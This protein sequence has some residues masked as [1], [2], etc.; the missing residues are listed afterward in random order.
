MTRTAGSAFP[1]DVAE[2]HQ[3]VTDSKISGSS[4]LRVGGGSEEIGS[5][6]VLQ[7]V[8]MPRVDDPLEV[9]P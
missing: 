8:I 2:A 4:S 3:D 5:C 1:A 7:R 6:H 9:R